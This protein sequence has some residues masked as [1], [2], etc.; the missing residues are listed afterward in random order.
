MIGEYVKG[1]DVLALVSRDRKITE[2]IRHDN[3]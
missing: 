3:R 2:N 1:S